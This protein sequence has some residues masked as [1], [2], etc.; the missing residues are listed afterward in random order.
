MLSYVC[1]LDRFDFHHKQYYGW[2][3][4]YI[5]GSLGSSVDHCA[6]AKKGWA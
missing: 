4:M 6:L 1:I 3:I 2:D 5:S